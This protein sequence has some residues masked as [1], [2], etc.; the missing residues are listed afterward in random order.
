M[1]GISEITAMTIQTIEIILEKESNNDPDLM[2]AV[3]NLLVRI[4]G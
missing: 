3:V 4:L 1:L 2:K